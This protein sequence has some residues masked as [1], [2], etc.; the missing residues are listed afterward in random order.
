VGTTTVGTV[1]DLVS[2]G[3]VKKVSSTTEAVVEATTASSRPNRFR[4]RNRQTTE[5]NFVEATTEKRGLVGRFSGRRRFSSS[6]TTSGPEVSEEAVKEAEPTSAPRKIGVRNRFAGRTRP[7][8]STSSTTTEGS[9]DEAQPSPS[10]PTRRRPPGSLTRRRL[11]TPTPDNNEEPKL[12]T[13]RRNPLRPRTTTTSTTALPIETSQEYT[14]MGPNITSSE[15]QISQKVS[16]SS[17][18]SVQEEVA[19]VQRGS[20]GVLGRLRSRSRVNNE[21]NVEK[22]VEPRLRGV[23]NRKEV[24]DIKDL[25]KGVI[26]QVSSIVT[27]SESQESVQ[28]IESTTQ[29]SIINRLKSQR[30][31][32]SLFSRKNKEN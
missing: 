4:G 6:S 28:L 15:E 17:T 25:P 18:E 20:A 11:T 10:Q 12:V 9:V 13:Q 19:P 31:P 32:G 5:A 21:K 3:D 2:S 1:E 8:T 14:T 16:V 30:K 26:V 7:T 27:E 23:L 22:V 24:I 29:G